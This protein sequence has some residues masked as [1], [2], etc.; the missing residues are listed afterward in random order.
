MRLVQGCGFEPGRPVDVRFTLPGGDVLALAARVDHG[1]ADDDELALLDPPAE[2]RQAL[3]R[4]VHERLG[5][6]A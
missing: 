1:D 5:L 6:P 4:Y 3:R 2:A